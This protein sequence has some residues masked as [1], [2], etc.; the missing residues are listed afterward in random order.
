LA[1]WP[2]AVNNESHYSTSIACGLVAGELLQ[3]VLS[4]NNSSSKRRNAACVNLRRPRSTARDDK[5]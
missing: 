2:F 3:I 5:Q 1:E 4:N